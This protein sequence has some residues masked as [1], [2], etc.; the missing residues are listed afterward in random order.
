MLSIS[1]LAQPGDNPMT[2]EVT[3]VNL[4]SG[5][6]YQI[7]AVGLITTGAPFSLDTESDTKLFCTC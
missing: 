4:T 7:K 5:I 3:I 2:A 1:A 6:Q